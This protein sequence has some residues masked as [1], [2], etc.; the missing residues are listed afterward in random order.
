MRSNGGNEDRRANNDHVDI[1]V[2]V[3]IAEAT[4]YFFTGVG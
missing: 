4:Q 1:V 3:H 2:K